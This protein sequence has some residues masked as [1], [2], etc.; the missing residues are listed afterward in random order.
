V[1][2]VARH[3]PSLSGDKAVRL[4]IADIALLPDIGD[5]LTQVTNAS[6]WVE[7]GD[8]VEDIVASV[9]ETVT[10]YYNVMLVGLVSQFL[11]AIPPG[12][13]QLDG[14]TYSE[15]DYPLLYAALPSQ[16]KN[17]SNFT[18][19]DMTDVYPYGATDSSEIGDSGGL[20]SYQ[21]SIAQLP[22]HS[23]LYTP[24]IIDID[25]KT[26][27]APDPFGARLGTPIS[28]TNTGSGNSIDNRPAFVEMLFAVYAGQE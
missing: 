21:L 22:A 7:V 18:L 10:D 12:W 6:H 26:V 17:G 3:T 1:A 15:N 8:P 13:L 25:V 16:L 4:V 2:L 9:F 14:A 27:G 5:A 23:H 19:P 20:N 24:P 11:V 28:T